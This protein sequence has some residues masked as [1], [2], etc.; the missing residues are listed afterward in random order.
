MRPSKSSTGP[1]GAALAPSL[2]PSGGSAV[3][4][5]GCFLS[6]WRHPDSHVGTW[7]RWKILGITRR[8]IIITFS[9]VVC[10]TFFYAYVQ[11]QGGWSGRLIAAYKLSRSRWRTVGCLRAV[12]PT[13]RL[14]G[15]SFAL[16]AAS[17]CFFFKWMLFFIR[18]SFICSVP[19]ATVNRFF[20]TTCFRVP[21]LLISRR[22]CA[23]VQL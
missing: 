6:P 4:D 20:Y 14:P 23:P 16:L 1:P 7:E 17:V 10:G 13:R 21:L 12:C 15:C 19:H 11:P 3:S 8:L 5:C 2:G 9:F 22:L 18:P